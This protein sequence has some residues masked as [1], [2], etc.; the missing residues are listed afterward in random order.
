MESLCEKYR[1]LC[2]KKSHSTVHDI[3]CY[4]TNNRVENKPK[5][6]HKI[7]IEA[8]E[9]YLMRKVKVNPFLSA[10]KLAIIAENELG[11]KASPS[12]IRNVLHKKNLTGRKA[13]HK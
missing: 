2:Q 7:F 6:A 10:P 5:K 1:R 8:D 9:R 11:K 12:T 13:F 3:K 4:K